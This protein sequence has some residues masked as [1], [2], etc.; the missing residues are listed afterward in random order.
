M[1]EADYLIA[2]KNGKIFIKVVGYARYTNSSEF[3]NFILND[4]LKK[5]HSE[6][7]FLDLSE[8]LFMDSTV[9]G[10]I[11]RL[12][13]YSISKFQTKLK[14]KSQNPELN[15]LLYNTGFHDFILIMD[16]MDEQNYKDLKTTESVE[17]SLGKIMLEAHVALSEMNE[18]NRKEFKSVVDMLSGSQED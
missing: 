17:N 3:A 15:N 6:E 5:A 18:V 13:G 10:L 14:V 8:T 9:M 12:A 16:D 11:A 7:V 2:I 4:L 1:N